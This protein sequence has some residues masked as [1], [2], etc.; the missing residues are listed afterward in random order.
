MYTEISEILMVDEAGVT[1]STAISNLDD[2]GNTFVE[3]MREN[4]E[5]TYKAVTFGKTVDIVAG[6]KTITKPELFMG[7]I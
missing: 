3:I 4:Q 1:K 7:Y 5:A 2:M 6:K